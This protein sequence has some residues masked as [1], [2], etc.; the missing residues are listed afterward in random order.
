[1]IVLIISILIIDSKPTSGRE[2]THGNVQILNSDASGL[3]LTFTPGNWQE[4]TVKIG[5]EEF[6]LFTF[7]GA[8]FSEEKPGLP[9]IPYQAIVVGIPVGAQVTYQIIEN[10][11]DIIDDVKSLPFPQITKQENWPAFNYKANASVYSRSR[12]FPTSPVKIDK[13]AFF[14]DQQIVRISLA[15]IQFLP[16]KGE[17][18]KYKRMVVR[19]NFVGGLSTSLP[20]TGHISPTE[21][22]LYRRLLLNY[23]QAA[24]WRLSHDRLRKLEKRR[25][26]N[27]NWYKFH[28]TEEGIYKIEGKQLES[29]G[30]NLSDIDP[31]KIKIFN[32]GGRELPRKINAPRPQGLVENAIL[33]SDGGDGRFDSGDF[34]LFYGRGVQGWDFDPKTQS[35]HHYINHYV[36]ENVY[37]LTWDDE[38][39]GKRMEVIPS[40]QPTGNV[41]EQYQGMAFVEDERINPLRSGLN[42]FGWE[43]ANSEVG[44]RSLSKLNLPNARP[45]GNVQ[46]RVRFASLTGGQHRFNIVMNGNPVDNV[47]FGGVGATY[48]EIR[49]RL[50]QLS[51]QNVLVP[52]ENR[53]EIFYSPSLQT[54]RALLDFVE[55][56]YPAD[57]R[58]VEDELAFTVFPAS[59]PQTYRISNFS[60]NPIRLFD[61][62]D[63]SDVKEIVNFQFSNGSLTFTDE[64]TPDKPKRYLALHSSKFKTVETLERVD[65][66]DL[67]R[68]DLG[69]EF[70]IITHEDFYSEALR[71]E[72]LREN[73]NPDNQLQ[74]EVVRIGDIYN[75]FSGGLMDP[76]A[77]RDFLKF[78]YDNWNPRPSYVLLLGDGDFD[79]RNIISKS[80]KNW[81]PT[82]QTDSLTTTSSTLRELVSRTSDSWY[83]YVSGND[84]V[85]DMAIGRINAQTPEDAKNAID[86]IIAY[87][88]QPLRGKWHNTVT[89]IGDDEL[90]TGGKPSAADVV[91]IL[92]TEDIAENHIP[93]CFDVEKIYLSEFPKVLSASVSGVIKPAAREALIRQINQGTLIVNYIGHGNSTQ[94][95]HEVVFH[96]SDNDRVQNHGKYIFFMAATCDWAL[97]DNPQSQSQ[98]EELLL[99][100]DRGA[101]AILSSARL[102]FSTLNARFN[103]VFYDNLFVA[104]GTT[105]R[106]GDAFVISRIITNNLNN[107]EK[108]HIYG[109][110]TLRLAI[111]KYEAVITSM[112]PDSIVALSTVTVQGEVRSNDQFLNDFN[113]KILINTFDSRKFVIHVPEAGSTQRYFLPGNSIFRGVVPVTN[114]KFTAKFIVPKDISYGG[115]QARISAYFWNDQVDGAGCQN[116]IRV[117]GSTNNLV[118]TEGPEVRISFK[119]QEDFVTGDVVNENAILVVDIADTVSGVNI[120]GEIGHRLTLTIDPDQ[121]T[122]LS[123]FYRFLGINSIDLT[124][125]FQFNEGDHLRGRVEFPI[126]FPREVEIGGRVVP[127][128][129][130]GQE[131]RHT[132]K[133]KAWDNAN[134][135]TTATVDVVVVHEEGLVLK[136]VLN[137]PNPFAEKTTFTFFLNRDAEVKIKIYTISGQLIRTLEYP[138]A[139]S[140]FNMIE[141]DG[142]DEEG[143]RPANG[144]YIFKLIAKSQDGSDGGQSEVVGRLAIVR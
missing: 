122:C 82:F 55:I 91:H 66:V 53:L 2:I 74:T 138:F 14:R 5:S 30:I 49:T 92:Q 129:L 115:Q 114:G 125:L 89:F 79:H 130:P 10:D 32:N 124:D 64:Q 43:Y 99:A 119:G 22:G 126:Q 133:V 72:S 131:D 120:T 11:Y 36:N 57:L 20:R 4:E 110:P 76:T 117:S 37:W 107:D 73:G 142:R 34:I 26:A 105:A 46:F 94:W 6:T 121:E 62:T 51:A 18:K 35:F 106:L 83:T 7:Q 84:R 48:L 108:F 3:T 96:K 95:A 54:G 98:A 141:W 137:Y 75:N 28:I 127:C 13:P 132:L 135:S 109:D 144:I 97:F 81:I 63:F 112:E 44:R 56:F 67:R 85:M 136:D 42:W 38:R 45:D 19:I 12:A 101:I 16:D 65:Y 87:E 61:V 77:I 52:G 68:T 33:V 104:P 41:I 111:P 128:T 69:A 23:Q 113:G 24:G 86:K 25:F 9:Q 116:N 1:F 80:D 59:G 90:V 143:D 58:A 50:F 15:G 27:Q 123:E 139:H 71:L 102:V 8:I 100:Q 118:D 60:K 140:G 78:T 47:Q 31:K 17:V 70:V 21:E 103:Q 40:G 134:N 29:M 39:D 88:T 93:R